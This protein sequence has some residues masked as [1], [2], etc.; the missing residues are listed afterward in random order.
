MQLIKLIPILEP[1]YRIVAENR[2]IFLFSP[3]GFASANDFLFTPV[4]TEGGRATVVEKLVGQ[5]Q[6]DEK[7]SESIGVQ[8]E[9]QSIVTADFCESRYSQVFFFL[10]AAFLCSMLHLTITL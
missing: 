6:T 10:R 4:V 8:R 3:S 2:L 5:Q 9:V 7:Q 1:R